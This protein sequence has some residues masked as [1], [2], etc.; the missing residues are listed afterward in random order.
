[1]ISYNIEDILFLDIET[2][3]LYADFDELNEKEKYLWEKISI[4]QLNSKNSLEEFYTS[5]RK[6]AEFGRIICICVGKVNLQNNTYLNLRCFYNEEEDKL[7]LEFKNFLNRLPI[8]TILCAHNGKEFDFPYLCR[9]ML[10]NGIELPNVLDI[11]GK[12]PEDINLL[13]TLELWKFGDNKHYTP[14]ELLAHVF[15]IEIHRNEIEG[16]QIHEVYY[17]YKEPEK[18]VDYCYKDVV[19][20]AQ[21]LLRFKNL[22]GVSTENIYY[23]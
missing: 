10:I 2:A 12:N 4:Y 22:E 3:P 5:A 8:N 17:K 15:G 1:M 11:V 16:N 19:T 6:F 9:R 18:I 7:L 14:L 13:D 20:I 23:V 21:L